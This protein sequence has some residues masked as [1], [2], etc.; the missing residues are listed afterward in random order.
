MTNRMGDYHTGALNYLTLGMINLGANDEAAA[1]PL[2]RTSRQ[3]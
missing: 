3:P 1:L 2:F